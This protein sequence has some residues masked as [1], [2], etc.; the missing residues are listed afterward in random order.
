MTDDST[1][2]QW[3]IFVSYAGDDAAEVRLI[4]DALKSQH[5]R[6]F[7]DEQSVGVHDSIGQRISQG[8]ANSAAMLVYYSRVYPTRSACQR[9]LTAAFLSAQAAGEVAQRILVVNPEPGEDHIE[10][11][12]LRDLRFQPRP[13]TGR[14]R[15][16][17]ARHVAEL[18]T[19]LPGRMGASVPVP[20]QP[21]WWPSWPV[22]PPGIVGRYALLCRLH[23]ALHA[24][25]FPLVERAAPVGVAVVSGLPGIGKTTLAEQYA[26]EFGSAFPGGIV[27]VSLPADGG[28]V[29]ATYNRSLRGIVGW[30]G[31]SIRGLPAERLRPMLA[32]R[33]T[34]RGEPCLWI[35]ED[36]PPGLPAE[37]IRGLIIP[38][39]MVRTI[40]T[41]SHRGY[42]DIG[43]PLPLEGL[44]ADESLELLAG[45][46][47][48]E[49][50]PEAAALARDF[51]GHPLLL[52]VAGSALRQRRGLVS[53]AE[54]RRRASSDPAAVVT[55]TLSDAD[56]VTASVL[57]IASVLAPAPI[58]SR[59]LAAALA[60]QHGWADGHAREV[61][62]DA[63][64]FLQQ[65]CIASL[66]GEA[67]SIHP[68]A[69]RAVSRDGAA[70]A[71]PAA[72]GALAELL[73]RRAP[74]A[75][76]DVHARHLASSARLAGDDAIPLLDW[77]AEADTRAGDYLSAGQIGERLSERLGVR[78]GP[79]DARTIRAVSAAVRAYTDAG[80]YGAAIR[81]A[82]QI[83]GD[84][85]LPV[86][87]ALAKAL[88]GLGRFAEA[89]PHWDTVVG[90]LPAVEAGDTAGWR[91][92]WAR[93]LRLRGRPEDAAAVLEALGTSAPPQR[94]LEEAYLYQMRGRSALAKR[95][96][97]QAVTA[98]R[99]AGL[100]NHPACLEAMAIGV[101]LQLGSIISLKPFPYS[102]QERGPLAELERLCGEYRSR[103]GEHSPLTL[104]VTVDYGVQLAGWGDAEAGRGILDEAEQAA[105]LWLGEHHPHRLRA[106]Y[107]LSLAA[108]WR[109]DFQAG[110]D[111]AG[112]AFEG[113]RLVL[114]ERHP[115]TLLS[116]LHSGVMR[117]VLG[118]AAAVGSVRRAARELR[119]IYGPRH[120]EF[121]R[122]W[123][124]QAFTYVPSPAVRAVIRWA[125][126][127]DDGAKRAAGR[128]RRIFGHARS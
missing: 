17:L 58:P 93:A 19:R 36:V 91:V 55:D 79:A 31:L 126:F 44:A 78:Y 99:E 67:V 81:L 89:A 88:D 73:A 7:I 101:D 128:A 74:D 104:A 90:A 85:E 13:A 87:H 77:L 118:D 40:L 127:M 59:L 42:G 20:G 119:Q 34:E 125:F 115:D 98:F 35:V 72:A 50:E 64:E 113:Q 5:L 12:E 22:P 46:Y 117:Y 54:Y 123:F 43:V 56:E 102:G 26:L 70:A 66:Q 25:R 1:S 97:D 109:R 106:L 3:H 107:G 6:V 75:E 122:A 15:R 116:L 28:D 53:V 18:V 84:L 41:T 69:F 8:L 103:Y 9:E 60:R 2:A 108:G 111:L 47:P 94:H 61:L 33:F 27:R 30:A 124:A 71:R 80:E 114:G 14:A 86:R 105:R 65:R 82:G 52:R 120:F 11:V 37:T 121:G 4:V 21:R 95:A 92:D 96:A 68:L 48:P 76:L 45:G 39:P 24:G 63:R 62:V 110:A 32:E 112:R 10:P 83:T 57:A 49:E 29:L 23:S 38:S 100:E 51:G 16:S